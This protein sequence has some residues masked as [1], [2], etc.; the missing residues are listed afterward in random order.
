MN[1]GL[2]VN[3]GA[4]PQPLWFAASCEPEVFTMRKYR[5]FRLKVEIKINIAACLIG[6]AAIISVLT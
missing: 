4:Y 2:S 3:W 6:T 1:G 5:S